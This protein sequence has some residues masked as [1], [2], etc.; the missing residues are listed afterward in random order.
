MQDQYNKKTTGMEVV[1]EK[2]ENHGTKFAELAKRC[3][4]IGFFTD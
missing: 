3:N 1:G 4:S 2:E